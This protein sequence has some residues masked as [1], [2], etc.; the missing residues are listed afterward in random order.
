VP[1]QEG[2]CADPGCNIAY[3]LCDVHHTRPGLKGA[4]LSNCGSKA[5][6]EKEVARNT[7]N[8][9]IMLRCYC[10]EHHAESPSIASV[11]LTWTTL[12]SSTASGF[13]PS[14]KLNAPT[15]NAK[16][17]DTS[18]TSRDVACSK[19]ASIRMFCASRATSSAFIKITSS[20]D[21]S[22]RRARSEG[23]RSFHAVTTGAMETVAG[24]A[25]E[26][27]SHAWYL[28]QGAHP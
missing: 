27:P 10:I 22:A 13:T 17:A 24:G 26:D 15:D 8:G 14:R 19:D 6:L 12:V 2:S 11:H 28:P 9:E 5:R 21:G 7:V 3:P 20:I 25:V 16:L 18:S 1:G 4:N 23:D